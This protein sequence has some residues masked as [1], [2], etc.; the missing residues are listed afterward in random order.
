M[1]FDDSSLLRVREPLTRRR[2]VKT[3]AKLAYATPVVAASF[4]LGVRQ[5]SAV[6]GVCPDDG[7]VIDC[8]GIDNADAATCGDAG[9]VGSCSRYQ[10]GDCPACLEDNFCDDA[11]VCG[12][13]CPDGFVCVPTCCDDQPRCLAPCGASGDMVRVDAVGGGRTTS[14]R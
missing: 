12:A 14:G 2:I 5:A 11:P 3:G 7:V 9:P 8:S 1:S 10:A 13:G 4:K 6:S